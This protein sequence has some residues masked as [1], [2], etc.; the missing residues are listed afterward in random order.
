MYALLLEIDNAV[1]VGAVLSNLIVLRSVVTCL[2]VPE[3]LALSL[4]LRITGIV[5]SLIEEL[6][7][8]VYVASQSVSLPATAVNA[9]ETPS[10]ETVGL[11]GAEAKTSS[12]VILIEISSPSLTKYSSPRKLSEETVKT[13]TSGIV[14]SNVILSPSNE[15]CTATPGTVK[16]S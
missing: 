15:F 12:A 7:G 11:L 8:T 6:S 1:N 5:P 3:L 16:R 13:V 4:K 10:S 14:E 2:G 9:T